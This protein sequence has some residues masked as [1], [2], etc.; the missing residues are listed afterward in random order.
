MKS[1]IFLCYCIEGSIIIALPLSADVIIASFFFSFLMIVF[2]VLHS[3]C[4]LWVNF[5]GVLYL[6]YVVRELKLA[7]YLTV[8]PIVHPTFKC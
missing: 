1:W 4:I 5:G 7:D 8:C 6:G 2:M 3:V